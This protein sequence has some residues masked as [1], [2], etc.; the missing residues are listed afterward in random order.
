MLWP[1]NQ[2]R[3]VITLIIIA[4]D[5]L[6]FSSFYFTTHTKTHHYCFSTYR[7]I[8]TTFLILLF[9]LLRMYTKKISRVLSD[10]EGMQLVQRIIKHRFI[11]LIMHQK[12]VFYEPQLYYFQKP[13][14]IFEESNIIR[15]WKQ[16]MMHFRYYLVLISYRKYVSIVFKETWCVSL[17]TLVV[18]STAG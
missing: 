12:W 2:T 18:C 5:F 16:S 1:V 13:F 7:C 17:C 8:K 4:K 9:G 15:I 3:V 14:N 10:A 6:S 11:A